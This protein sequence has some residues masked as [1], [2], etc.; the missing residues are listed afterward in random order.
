MWTERRTDGFDE[1]NSRFSKF[2]ER[3]KNPR[4]R[5]AINTFLGFIETDR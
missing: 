1:A 4:S 3:A 5:C 2:C